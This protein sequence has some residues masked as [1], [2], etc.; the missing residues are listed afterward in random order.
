MN[1]IL[2]TCV[3]SQFTKRIPKYAKEWFESQ[4]GDN[5]FLASLLLQKSAMELSD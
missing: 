1:Y 4:E 3:V 5:L 2:D